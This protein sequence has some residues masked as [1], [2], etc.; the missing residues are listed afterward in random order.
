MILAL[1]LVPEAA[2][3]A[4][5]PDTAGHWAEPIIDR[6]YRQGAVAGYPDG[7]FRPD[8]PLR[9]V[10]AAVMVSRALDLPP[11]QG[12]P[13]SDA[14]GI[15]AWARSQVAAAVSLLQGV[16]DGRGGLAFQGE[17]LLTRAQLAVLL[18]RAYALAAGRALPRPAGGQPK[19][20]DRAAIP[21]WAAG[22]AAA[23][24]AAGLMH[25]RP[26]GRFD[27]GAPA[28]RAELAVALYRLLQESGRGGDAGRG[29]GGEV[30]GGS[31]PGTGPYVLGYYAG[32]G[33]A[34]R[35]LSGSGD[36]VVTMVAQV[37]FAVA[38]DGRVLGRPDQALLAQ[39]RQAGVPVV[40]VVQN[41]L[42]SGFDR[43]LVHQLLN[44]PEA[45]ERAAA[46]MAG[47]VDRHGYAGINLDLEN[48]PPGDRQALTAF[49]SRLA[50]VLHARG[51]LLL[52]AVPAKTGEDPA[53]AW[54]GA[55]DYRALGR[56]ADYVVVM[57]YDQ[58]WAGGSPGPVAGLSWVE[59]VAGYAARVIPRERILLGTAAYGY[60]WPSGGHGRA[61][62]ARQAP[63]LAAA[64]GAQIRWD[65]V[66]QVPFFHYRAGGVDHVAYYENA[67]SLR[68]KLRLARSRD[69][70]GVALW[71]VG[72]EEADVWSLLAEYRQGGAPAAALR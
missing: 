18:D 68:A 54:S 58:H 71:R 16:P 42:G 60:I 33:D 38:A 20:T 50:E 62:T 11:G 40:A 52:V 67:H 70:A 53:D 48:V 69:L 63:R 44:T 51:A 24:Q 46:E 3:A 65:D 37:G 64:H 41:D 45:V 17:R 9:R 49:V 21:S 27:P 7:S 6:L 36:G 4:V 35:S 34:L 14:A 25:G 61:V 23:L 47:L 26:D 30:G 59:R 8:R 31:R 19:Y 5:F 55:F 66:D 10:E 12:L 29:A 72:F 13:Y 2:Q 28:T 1:A 57:A 22:A 39:A 43:S 56:A 32:G 15:P